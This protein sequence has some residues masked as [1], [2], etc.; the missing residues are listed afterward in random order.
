MI[1]VQTTCD[2]LVTKASSQAAWLKLGNGITLIHQE[3]PTVSVASVDIW[4]GAGAVHDPQ[5]CLGMAHFLEHMVFK[6]TRAIA[7]GEF[8]RAIESAGGMSNAATSL[9]YTHYTLTVDARRFQVT[10]PYL[11]QILLHA[12]LDAE[13]LEKERLVVLEELR[14]FNDD[15]DCLAY[16]NLLQ[17][18]YGEHSYSRSVL[19]DQASV[20]RI[21]AEQMRNFHRQ[22]YRPDNM[23]IAIAGAV[24]QEEAIRVIDAA[25][26]D[27]PFTRPNIFINTFS[28]NGINA[29]HDQPKLADAVIPTLRR[30]QSQSP[31]VQQARLHMAWMGASVAN[32]QEAIALELLSVILTEGRSACL[33]QD[34]VESGLVQDVC[35]SFAMQQSASLFTISAYLEAD[36][37]E[38]VESKIM[39]QLANL[40]EQPISLAELNKAKRSLC[41]HFTFALESPS[42]L[43]N[44]LGYHA[45]LGC[46]D[47]CKNWANAYGAIVRQ[48]Q[49][50]DL[51]DLVKKYFSPE[52]RVVTSLIPA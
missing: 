18:A 23:T 3:I 42:Q 1:T 34:L 44:F 28:N 11:A 32:V 24:S 33:V 35:S 48:T 5:D 36:D 29:N 22:Y 15:P 19:G 41:N 16:Q 14:Q 52:H 37:L 7:V 43:A 12:Q 13:E 50:E 25:F 27:D 4:I 30:H 51:Q 6:G 10:L 2:R 40:R 47:L 26:C 21:S 45:L 46:E 9:D 8:D 39:Q 49:L 31:L 20:Q 17:T 38:L